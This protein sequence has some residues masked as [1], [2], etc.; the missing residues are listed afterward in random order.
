MSNDEVTTATLNLVFE[1]K[2]ISCQISGP[3]NINWQSPIT[4]INIDL[5]GL[6]GKISQLK[7]VLNS[8]QTAIWAGLKD[9]L[10]EPPNAMAQ[11]EFRNAVERVISEGSA[12]YSELSNKGF[13]AILEK[14]NSTLK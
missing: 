10:G 14:I 9:P 5:V 1:S 6:S 12:L 13:R 8:T 4:P 7:K 11:N 3:P 2:Q